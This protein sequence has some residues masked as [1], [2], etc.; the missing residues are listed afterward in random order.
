MLQPLVAGRRLHLPHFALTFDDAAEAGTGLVALTEDV[1]GD[2]VSLAA[3]CVVFGV[4][5]AM[6]ARYQRQDSA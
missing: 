5:G 1:V 2:N 3:L 6:G 4:S